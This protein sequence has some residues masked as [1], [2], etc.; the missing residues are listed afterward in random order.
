M[1]S[2]LI[3]IL[4]TSA[5]NYSKEK[6]FEK[7]FLQSEKKNLSVF[8][9]I[10]SIINIYVN[11]VKRKG[12]NLPLPSDDL[13]VGDILQVKLGDIVPV[14]GVLISGSGKFIYL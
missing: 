6:Q 5:N 8:F 3:I 11:K 2:V 7:L 12:Q 10:Y 1:L 14:D 13:L 9:I 4:V